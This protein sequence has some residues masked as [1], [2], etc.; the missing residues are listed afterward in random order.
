VAVSTKSR[1][2]NFVHGSRTQLIS[3]AH[4]AESNRSMSGRRV[5]LIHVS[6][7]SGTPQPDSFSGSL[8]VG[9]TH[10]L[11]NAFR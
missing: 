6:V 8:T 5:V 9:I 11:E 4:A 3:S 10:H 7:I 2:R 1:N